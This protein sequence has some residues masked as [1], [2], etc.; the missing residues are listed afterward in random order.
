M[1]RSGYLAAPDRFRLEWLVAWRILRARQKESFISVIAII[2]LVG[3]ALGVAVLIITLSVMNGFRSELLNRILGLNAHITVTARGVPVSD[4]DA[5]VARLRSV[6][7]IVDIAPVVEGD[8]MAIYRESAQAALIRGLRAEDLARRHNV[9]SGL[10]SGRL[11]DFRDGT[12]TV[13]LGERLRREIRAN[14]GD[15]L[16]LLTPRNEGGVEENVLSPYTADFELVGSFSVRMPEY[17]STYVFMPLDQAQ[18][19]LGLQPGEVSSLEILVSDTDQSEAIAAQVAATIGEGYAVTDWRT[20]NR[21]FIG[22]LLVERA[23]MFVILSLIVLV[24]ALNIVASFTMLVRSKSRS[25]AILRT[26]GATRGAVLRIFF[27]AGAVVGLVGTL[28][29]LVLGLGFSLNAE[30][31]RRVFLALDEAGI[32]GPLVDFFARLPA[33][34]DPFEVTA[35]IVMAVLVA[36]AAS[37]YVAFRAARLE[38]VEA[39]RYE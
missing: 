14:L 24:A 26:M 3:I 15:T 39:L 19:F 18:S 38:P 35:I 16:T 1:A 9:V 20:R 31:I 28:I 34:V 25:I 13:I 22:A 23:V 36:L 5:L 12:A 33:I 29:G 27:M 37:T 21:T 6:P 17:D 30:A 10:M 11:S 32:R 8:A 2:S 7:G 4:P